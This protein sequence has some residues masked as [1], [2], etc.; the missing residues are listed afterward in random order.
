MANIVLYCGTMYTVQ[1]SNVVNLKGRFF[2]VLNIGY[3]LILQ[4][5]CIIHYLYRYFYFYDF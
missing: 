4:Y 2:L 5:Y 1:Y 3:L